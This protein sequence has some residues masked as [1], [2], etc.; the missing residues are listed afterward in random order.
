MSGLR[1]ATLAVLVALSTGC[2]TNDAEEFGE[3]LFQQ[4]LALWE[5]EGPA[6][7]SFNVARGACCG[8]PSSTIRVVVENGVAVS[9]TYVSTGDPLEQQYVPEYPT[10]RGLFDIATAARAQKPVLSSL[11]Y[12]PTYGFI[13][14]MQFDINGTTNTDN[15]AYSVSEFEPTP[16]PE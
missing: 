10:L 1:S 5:A 12:D 2:L 9:R 16:E 11:Q 14:F 6:N 13:S 3:Q 15:F 8:W 7:Y 4:N